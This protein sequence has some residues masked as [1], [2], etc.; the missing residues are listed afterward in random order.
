MK[1]I[2]IWV[3]L[4]NRIASGPDDEVQ[5]NHDA[6]LGLAGNVTRDHGQRERLGRPERERDVVADEQADFLTEG[7]ER[8]SHETDGANK[9]A[10]TTVSK[11]ARMQKNGER[12][13]E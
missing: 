4:T 8:D 11:K 2:I 7:L 1:V 10:A 12:L 13:T 9:G 5:G 3:S 6:L